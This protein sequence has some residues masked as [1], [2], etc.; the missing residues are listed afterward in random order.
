MTRLTVPGSQSQTAPDQSNDATPEALPDESSWNQDQR[1]CR[2][3]P[4]HR[5]PITKE[6]RSK[7]M[8]PLAKTD[9]H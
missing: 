2:S 6:Q 7:P 1:A 4:A 9:G 5:S 3:P 8:R